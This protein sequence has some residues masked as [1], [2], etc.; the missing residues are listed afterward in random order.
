MSESEQGSVDIPVVETRASATAPGEQA[1]AATSLSCDPLNDD[2]HTY[3]YVIAMLRE[4]FGYP[5]EKGYQLAHEVDTAGRAVV[6][7]TTLNMPS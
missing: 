7:T 2:D 1:Q 4:L 5:E 3:Q 6:T